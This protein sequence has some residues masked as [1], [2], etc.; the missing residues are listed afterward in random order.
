MIFV[1]SMGDLFHESVPFAW[2]A[3]VFYAMAICYWHTF[4]VL[5]KRPERMREFFEWIE[6]RKCG[7]WW[8]T[9]GV[10]DAGVFIKWPLPNVWLGVTVEA[11]EYLHRVVSLLDC[12][13]AVRFVSA[14][15]LLAGL[16]FTR[17]DIPTSGPGSNTPCAP[18]SWRRIDSL[19]GFEGTVDHK[20]HCVGNGGA[21]RLDWVIVGCET[22]AGAR[23]NER[24]AALE[25]QIVHQCA[26]AHVA[27]FVKKWPVLTGGGRW[28]WSREKDIL[29]AWAV[30]QYPKGV[31][32]V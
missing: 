12:P 8:G 30:R 15:P 16:D 6:R 29:P 4:Q 13:A 1:N 20:G 18:P 17:I 31:K 9:F 3:K 14:E 19:G 23:I 2:I 27:C 28:T 26:R 5:T 7:M 22:G 11:P 24:T 10:R 21:R 32:S 25:Q